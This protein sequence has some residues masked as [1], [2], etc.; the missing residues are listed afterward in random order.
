V[1]LSNGIM[2]IIFAILYMKK[3][4]IRNLLRME[5]IIIGQHYSMGIIKL[6]LGFLITQV[7]NLNNFLQ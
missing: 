2:D 1:F 3:V 6:I 7:E 4:V 5:P